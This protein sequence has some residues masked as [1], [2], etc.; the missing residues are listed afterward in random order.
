[1]AAGA[2][3]PSRGGR[4]PPWRHSFRAFD[5]CSAGTISGNGTGI[6]N[7][8]GTVE[9]LEDNLVHGNGTD[10]AGI[11]TPITKT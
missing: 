8:D 5:R 7:T 11:L 3:V 9:T 1:M 10:V 2:V 4:Q 6:S